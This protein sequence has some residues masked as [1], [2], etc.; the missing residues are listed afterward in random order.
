[1]RHQIA[2]GIGARQGGLDIDAGKALPIDL[3]LGH[4]FL[5]HVRKN[6]SA[7]EGCLALRQFVETLSVGWC[8]RQKFREL[9]NRVIDIALCLF[10]HDYQL[11]GRHVAGQQ[12]AVAR[13]YQPPD[14]RHGLDP[15]TV[16]LGAGFIILVLVDLQGDNPWNEQSQQYEQQDGGKQRA[17][18]DR[19]SVRGMVSYCI[20][21]G[22][23]CPYLFPCSESAGS[24]T[25]LSYFA[26]K[27][28]TRY[29]QALIRHRN[30]PNV[31]SGMPR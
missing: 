28:F 19:A 14:G 27:L 20:P 16:A 11:I 4:I 21:V 2:L 15:H 30:W 13:T 26:P 6:G 23:G 29:L 22:H 31:P 12:F 5:S 25:W 10:R 1:M 7:Q 18:Q 8:D 9:A 24:R 3:E 17:T